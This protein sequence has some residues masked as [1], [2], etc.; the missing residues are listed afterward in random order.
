MSLRTQ[1]RPLESDG[2]V[3][4]HL[5]HLYPCGNTQE[6]VTRACWRPQSWLTH[7]QT[8]RAGTLW[9]DTLEPHRSVFK[10]AAWQTHQFSNCSSS[11]GSD[12]ERGNDPET[13]DEVKVYRLTAG[14]VYLSVQRA[15]KHSAEEHVGFYL[16]ANHRY[17]THP[18]SWN[19]RIDTNLL[20]F[21]DTFYF[22]HQK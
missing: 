20:T 3:Y 17:E 15:F 8:H 21:P 4:A 9:S 14:F 5:T 22:S 7:T 2:S 18:H 1:R 19:H 6:V 16:S 12:R 11:T 13:S 10:A